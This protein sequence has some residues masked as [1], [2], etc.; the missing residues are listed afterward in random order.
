MWVDDRETNSCHQCH[1]SFSLLLR[2]HHCRRCGQ[3]FCHACSRNRVLNVNGI[4]DK[5]MH[6]LCDSCMDRLEMTGRVIILPQESNGCVNTSY[7]SSGRVA[8]VIS[9]SGSPII[10]DQQTICPVCNVEI[11]VRIAEGHLKRCLEGRHRV[12][13][14]RYQ[15]VTGGNG[16]E[17]DI[18]YEEMNH[19]NIAI[20]NCLCQ[21]HQH[22]IDQWFALGH[23]CPIHPQ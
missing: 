18:C 15:V 14:D 17:C 13:G 12:I 4:E 19:G 21:F 10:M 7:G 22:C 9:R 23:A 3:I 16:K 8:A 11:S 2:R 6:R 1:R 20:L 5:Q